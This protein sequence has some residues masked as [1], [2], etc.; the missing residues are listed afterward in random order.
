MKRLKTSLHP[1]GILL[2]FFLYAG[3]EKQQ[4][5]EAPPNILWI[6]VEDIGPALGS[7]GD[8][9]ALTPNIDQLASEGVVYKRAYATA[10][11]CAPARSALITGIYATSMGT[12]HLRSVIPIPD[13]IVTLPEHMKGAGYYTTNN[14]KTDYN[15][16]P[17]GMWDDNGNQAHWRNRPEGKPFFSVFNYG[18]THEGHTNSPPNGDLD[19]LDEDELHDPAQANL[20]PYFPDT[21]E[22]RELWARQY[23]LI[24]VMDKQVGDLLLQLEEDGLSDNTIIFFFSDHGFGLPRYKRWPQNTGHHV[25]LIIKVPEKYSH[26][27]NLSEGS[28][29]DQ[30]VSFIDFAPTVL[31]LAGISVPKVMQGVPFMNSDQVEGRNYVFGARSRADD[32][33]EVSRTVISDRYVYIRNYMPH[34]PMIQDAVIFSD[35]KRGY[36]E[37]NRL[38]RENKLE[39]PAAEFYLPK[40]VEELYDL[41]EDPFELNNL[42]E[43]EDLI[44][45]KIEMKNVLDEWISE[46]VDVGFLP[47]AEMMLR[48]KGSTPYEYAH[49]KSKYNLLRI[50]AAAD[51]VGR[52]M[53]DEYN[54]GKLLENPDSG[55]RFWAATAAQAR[56]ESSDFLADQLKELLDDPSPSVAIKAAETLALWGREDASVPVL[57]QYLRHEEETVMLEAAMASRR[58]GTKACPLIPTIKEI[59]PKISGEVWGRYKNWYYP[60]FIGMALDQVRINCGEDVEIIN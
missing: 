51:L 39:G 54:I 37:L 1:L 5:P 2:I 18:I 56:Q 21:Q 8:P 36:A 32:V 40:P 44:E 33:Y 17:E 35:S 20:P 19:P 50:K 4:L 22:M 12:Q 23:D 16:D 57:S 30:L 43:N 27:I 34:Q 29:T 9:Y 14:A 42:A 24:T 55:V 38:Q 52:E 47:E 11:I 58:I 15:F 59:Y 48:S 53:T 49:D 10:P 60:M 7:Y 3:C 25:P 46:T 31:N 6:S 41:K 26:L 13:T 28:E 45:V